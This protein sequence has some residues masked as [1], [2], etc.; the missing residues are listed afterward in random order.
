MKAIQL[1]AANMMYNKSKMKQIWETEGL[2]YLDPG[3]VYKELH[4]IFLS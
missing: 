4:N 1:R 2:P 3:K